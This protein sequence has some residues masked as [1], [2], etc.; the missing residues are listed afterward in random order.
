ARQKVSI[1]VAARNEEENIGRLLDCLVAQVYPKELL[2]IIVVD[3]HSI[4]GTA[5]IVC[6][7]KGQGVQLIQLNES[8]AL[9]SYKKFAI[10]NATDHSTAVIIVP[11]AAECRVGDHWL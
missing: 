1:I 4:D 5:D 3:D 7:Y 10:F 2:E 11:T 9:N 6:Q 8:Q